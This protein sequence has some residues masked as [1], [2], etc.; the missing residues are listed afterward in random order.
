MSTRSNPKQSVASAKPDL[1]L[2]K[3]EAESLQLTMMARLVTSSA[4]DDD[5]DGGMSLMPASHRGQVSMAP[6]NP[7][8]GFDLDKGFVAEAD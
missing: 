4:D 1:S 3:G 7:E 5:D 6:C 8:W 2:D